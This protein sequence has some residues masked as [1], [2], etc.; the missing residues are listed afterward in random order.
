MFFI[1][2]LKIR[3]HCKL[4]FH[5]EKQG[6]T[7][8]LARQKRD[9]TKLKSLREQ[10]GRLQSDIASEVG[11]TREYLSSLENGRRR[12]TRGLAEKLAE[13]YDV[14]PAELLGYPLPDPGRVLK[15]NS[16]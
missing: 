10:T 13:V 2:T 4:E 9:M 5:A 8:P 3:S 15:K 1:A 6:P 12:L 7:L 16:F 14:S 11:I